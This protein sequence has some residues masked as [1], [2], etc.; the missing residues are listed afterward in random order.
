MPSVDGALSWARPRSSMHS[1]T[2]L[3]SGF[4]TGRHQN[5]TALQRNLPLF[6]QQFGSIIRTRFRAEVVLHGVVQRVQ[7]LLRTAAIKSSPCMVTTYLVIEHERPWH[8][9][10]GCRTISDQCVFHQ[11]TACSGSCSSTPF[12]A[13]LSFQQYC[14][15]NVHQLFSSF[16]DRTQR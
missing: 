9:F 5:S 1:F 14:R 6:W 3:G 12:I 16:R 7:A 10:H 8:C 2:C 4:S 11:A 15:V 13:L